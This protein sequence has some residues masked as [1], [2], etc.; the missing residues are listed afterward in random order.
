VPAEWSVV[1]EL[2]D[3]VV[4][5]CLVEEKS[6][7]GAAKLCFGNGDTAGGVYHR[8]FWSDNLSN[9]DATIDSF[10]RLPSITILSS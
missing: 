4:W 10:R 8:A 7:G 3:M 6:C 5:R 1:V 2:T 9:G